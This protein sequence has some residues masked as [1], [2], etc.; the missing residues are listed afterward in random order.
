[1]FSWSDD[2]YC[3]KNETDEPM[4]CLA[5]FTKHAFEGT[6]CQHNA[7]TVRRYI[8]IGNE[9][10]GRA[11]VENTYRP[12][13]DLLDDYIKDGTVEAFFTDEPSYMACYFNLLKKP[14]EVSHIHD[15]TIPLFAMLHWSKDLEKRFCQ[16]YGYDLM[17][18]IPQLF[19]GGTDECKKIR[20]DYYGLLTDLASA[21]FFSPLSDFCQERGARFSGHILLEEKITDHLKYE[22]NFFTLLKNMHIPGMDMLDSLPERVWKKSF[23]P[24]I[25]S[26]VSKL[27]RDG[28]VLDEVPCY[29]QNKFN[30]P[31][32]PQR[33]S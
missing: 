19:I 8:D 29:F 25:V 6:H 15:E 12:Y 27:Y 23:T 33:T 20:R 21:G 24:L 17:P 7:A 30:T 14:P 11:F 22:G 16:R 2:G 3:L 4:L 1:M 13:C 10:S 18:H 28:D 32:L 9:K 5:F 26:S 31:R